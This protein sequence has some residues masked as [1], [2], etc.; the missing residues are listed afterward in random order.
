MTFYDPAADI[1]SDLRTGRFY[2]RP[3]TTADSELDYEAVMETRASLRLWEQSSWPEDHFTVADNRAD[4]AEMQERHEAN[5]AYTYTV[6]D[7]TGTRCLGCVYIFPHDASFLAKASVT[8]TADAVWS[9]SDAVV[10]FWVRQSEMDRGADAV[11]LQE[12]RAWFRKEWQLE[13]V[14]FVTSEAFQHQ[15]DLMNASDLEVQFEL[16]EPEKSGRFL[17]YG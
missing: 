9:A 16:T 7:P 1:P 17:V 14:V 11:L 15:V 10:Y 8:P 5:R 3:L 6:L 4:L 2:L 13:N 12:L